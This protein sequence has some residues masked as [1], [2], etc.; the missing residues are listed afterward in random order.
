MPQVYIVED[1]SP[2]AFATG[3]DPQH[4]VVAVTTGALELFDH[5]ELEGVIGHELSHVGNYD[6]RLMAMVCTGGVISLVSH[7]FLA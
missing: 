6:T 7:V 5:N 2:N 4:A 1:P 3:R